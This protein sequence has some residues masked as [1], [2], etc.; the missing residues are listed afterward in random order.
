MN[1]PASVAAVRLAATIPQ[2]PNQWGAAQ[3]L[4]L[5]PPDTRPFSATLNQQIAQFPLELSSLPA[6]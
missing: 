2:F 6:T 4:R 1:T 3:C 5:R